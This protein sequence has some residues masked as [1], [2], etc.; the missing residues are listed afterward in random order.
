M[1]GGKEVRH[2]M[3]PDNIAVVGVIDEIILECVWCGEKVTKA[4][5]WAYCL[6]TRLAGCKECGGREGTCDLLWTKTGACMDIDSMKGVLTAK[7][8]LEL[9]FK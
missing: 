2:K 5:S 8:Q 7:Q 3:F 1:K 4:Q 9:L 6:G